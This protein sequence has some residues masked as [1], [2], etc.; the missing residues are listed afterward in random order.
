LD[1]LVKT[2]LEGKFVLIDLK[3]ISLRFIEGLTQL[4][5]QMVEKVIEKSHQKDNLK[6]KLQ[7]NVQN[8]EKQTSE[9]FACQKVKDNEVDAECDMHRQYFKDNDLQQFA[10]SDKLLPSNKKSSRVSARKTHSTSVHNSEQ[11]PETNSHTHGPGV[12]VD[13][14][15]DMDGRYSIES[16]TTNTRC[17]SSFVNT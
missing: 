6:K 9:S 10:T 12:Q 17:S 4:E 11:Q 2:D 8:N 5:T 16:F 15:A 3:G 13:S 1:A 7:S 14:D